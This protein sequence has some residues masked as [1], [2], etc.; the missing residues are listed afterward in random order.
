MKVH[1]SLLHLHINFHD[2]IHLTLAITKKTAQQSRGSLS[3]NP[4]LPDDFYCEKINRVLL[5][6]P[7]IPEFRWRAQHSTAEQ[8]EF[9]PEPGTA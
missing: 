8:R 9:E 1:L 3:R 7:L 5:P 2:Q 4:E 6:F